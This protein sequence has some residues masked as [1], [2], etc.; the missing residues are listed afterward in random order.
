MAD[1]AGHLVSVGASPRRS[2]ADRDDEALMLLAAAGHRAAFEVLVRRYL[3]KLTNYCSKYVG[4]NRVGEELAQETLLEAWA[5]RHR[6]QGRGKLHVYLFVL[7]R[8][9]CRNQ[10][11]NEGRRRWFWFGDPVHE[12]GGDVAAG[13][14]DQLDRMVEE[15]RCRRVRTC[16][17]NLSPKLREAVLLRF[18]QGLDYAEVAR[19][20]GRLEGLHAP[21]PA[22]GP[23]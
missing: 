18:D 3:P 11:R 4:S 10:L 1:T 16:L 22:P 6:Y 12:A 7:A 9:R 8:N 19:I 23:G 14:P 2:L 13:G 5:Q 17:L 15:E 20:V 21:R